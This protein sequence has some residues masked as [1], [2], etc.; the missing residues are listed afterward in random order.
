MILHF[1]V[2]HHFIFMSCYLSILQ[3]WYHIEEGR[4]SLCKRL[5]VLRTSR[6]CCSP[7]CQLYCIVLGMIG[8]WPI[9]WH[10]QV[11]T[12]R[13]YNSEYKNYGLTCHLSWHC[14]QGWT[15]TGIPSILPHLLSPLVESQVHPLLHKAVAAWQTALISQWIMPLGLAD[16]TQGQLML[17]KPCPPVH[18]LYKVK[19]YC[20]LISQSRV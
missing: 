8:K 15:C 3:H 12:V 6:Q 19:G 14:C 9:K 1:L 4:G 17:Y 20:D 18:E 10:D 5:V 16:V 11:F 2:Y 13:H 7:Q